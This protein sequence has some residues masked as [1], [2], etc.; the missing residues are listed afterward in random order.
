MFNKVSIS[1]SNFWRDV[2]RKPATNNFYKNNNTFANCKVV[3]AVCVSCWARGPLNLCHMGISRVGLIG[4]VGAPLARHSRQ[5][6]IKQCATPPP[7]KK[8]TLFISLSEQNST[9]LLRSV[10]LLLIVAFCFSLFNKKKNHL[11]TTC[12]QVI[13][14]PLLVV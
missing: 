4:L 5:K 12:L 6:S 2:Y 13:T 3:E 11:F 1:K 14:L 7:K 8:K 9:L 10:S